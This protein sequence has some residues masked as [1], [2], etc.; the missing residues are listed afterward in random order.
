[1]V[2]KWILLLALTVSSFG[3][4]AAKDVAEQ[5]AL[6]AVAQWNAVLKQ[7]KLDELLRLYAKDALVLLPSGEVVKDPAAI[8]KFWQRLLAERSGR[9][10]LDLDK[11]LFAQG[12]TVI[13]TLRWSNLDGGMKYQ[14]EGVIYNVFKRQP[15][16]SWTAQVQQWN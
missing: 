16:G 11:V 7:K 4:A 1:M 9:Y 15:D 13:S 8:R 6:V 3:S 12:D 14:Y 2:K 5:A 10:A